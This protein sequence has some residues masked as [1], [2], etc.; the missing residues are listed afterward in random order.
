MPYHPQFRGRRQKARNYALSQQERDFCTQIISAIE[1]DPTRLSIVAEN[2]AHYRKMQF[3]SRGKLRTLDE[4]G[5][6]LE[7]ENSLDAIKTMLLSP[8]RSGQ[9][10][11]RFPLLF[12]NVLNPPLRPERH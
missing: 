1:Q 6:A 11:R 12:R 3:L 5:W 4:L 2:L 10:L 8:T 9:R 7:V